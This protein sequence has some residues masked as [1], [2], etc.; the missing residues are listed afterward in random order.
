MIRI[1]VISCLDDMICVYM[2]IYLCICISSASCNSPANKKQ[3]DILIDIFLDNV[4]C[5]FGDLFF[6]CDLC[7][8]YVSM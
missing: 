5:I 7:K 1:F 6:E 8:C 4:I 3:I 2:F